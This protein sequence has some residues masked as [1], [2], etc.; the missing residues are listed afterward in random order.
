MLIK[1]IGLSNFSKDQFIEAQ[2]HSKHKII[3]NQIHYNLIHKE[4]VKNSFL[5]YAKLNDIFIA[6]W[7]PLQGGTLVKK[8]PEIM[9]KMCKKYEKTPAQIAINWLISQKNVITLAKSSDISHLKDNLGALGWV[10]DE[11]DIK[12][13]NEKYPAQK[14]HSDSTGVDISELTHVMH[15]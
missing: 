6:A 11:E 5:E 2:K 9:E 4:Y 3:Y 7:R 12:L 10:I 1:N 13:L 8:V 14:Y 15:K